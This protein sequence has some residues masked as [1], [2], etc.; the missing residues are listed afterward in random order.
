MPCDTIQ[1]VNLVITEALKPHVMETLKSLGYKTYIRANGVVEFYSD[2]VYYDKGTYDPKTGKIEAREE[3]IVQKVRQET[4][5]T[6]TK[7]QMKKFGWTAKN[8]KRKEV[9]IG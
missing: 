2:T 8:V 1:V 9:K 4:A 5:F 3:S 7:S 6:M